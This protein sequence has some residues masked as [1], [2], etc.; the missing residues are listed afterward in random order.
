M[1]EVRS[2]VGFHAIL[3]TQLKKIAPY[4]KFIMESRSGISGKVLPYEEIASILVK[5]KP[6]NQELLRR[7]MHGEQQALTRFRDEKMFDAFYQ[8]WQKRVPS[9]FPDIATLH[10]LEKEN[11]VFEGISKVRPWVS[12]LMNHMY[13]WKPSMEVVKSQDKVAKKEKSNTNDAKPGKEIPKTPWEQWLFNSMEC[14]NNTEKQV[15]SLKLGLHGIC[16]TLPE[17]SKDLGI[18]MEKVR[19]IQEKATEKAFCTHDWK[20]FQRLIANELG[21]DF[22]LTQLSDLAKKVQHLGGIENNPGLFVRL[23]E[24]LEN[25]KLHHFDNGIEPWFSIH[26]PEVWI[27]IHRRD[28]PPVSP[29]PESYFEKNVISPS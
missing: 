20:T 16:K 5:G 29:L 12:Y 3:R 9:G 28:D 10:F 18:P 8:E 15:L 11:P 21:D 27:N 23:I 4:Q 7:V 1:E 22:S 13:G 14:L 24:R 2:N 19:F 17:I 26:R 6:V 25:K